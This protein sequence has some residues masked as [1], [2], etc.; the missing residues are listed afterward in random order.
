VR[1]I[2]GIEGQ[3]E[4]RLESRPD[5]DELA[6]RAETLRA[7]LDAV[8]GEIYQVR[9]ESNQDPLNYPIKLNNRIGALLGVVQSAE[10]RP[11]AQS[12]QVFELL[13]GE[14]QLQL[15]R[16]HEILADD[17]PR[18]NQLLEARGLAPV[19]EEM[20]PEEEPEDEG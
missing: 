3:I 16:L 8:E 13:S 12:Y 11:T 6:S 17:L 15:D 5:D 1:L 10:A 4:D 9:N 19:R 2:R 14:L 18:F 7:A 20:I